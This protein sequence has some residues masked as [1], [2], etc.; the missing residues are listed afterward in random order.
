M[1]NLLT[2]Q[3]VL[4]FICMMQMHANVDI[5][6]HFDTTDN[7]NFGILSTLDSGDLILSHR[8]ALTL[9]NTPSKVPRQ[10]REEFDI[11]AESEVVRLQGLRALKDV[12]NLMFWRPQKVGSSSLLSLL[13]SFGYR[14]NLLPR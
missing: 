14:Y 6:A 13:V 8:K 7:A 2:L 10:K 11:F 3:V 12:E 4:T 9:T 1:T 5:G